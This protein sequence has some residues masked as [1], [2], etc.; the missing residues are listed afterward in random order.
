MKIMFYVIYATS[1][2][3][4][5]CSNADPMA[6]I[7]AIQSTQ[8]ENQNAKE[9]GHKLTDLAGKAA[10]PVNLEETKVSS[11]LNKNAVPYIGRYRVEINCSDPYIGCEQGT[12]NFILNLLADGTA[13]R[14]IV[15]MGKITFNSSHQY[16]QDHW[17]YDAINH[18]II[19]Q[20]ESGVKFYYWIQPDQNL[21]MDLNKI[22]HADPLNQ[23]FFEEG[24]PLPQQSYVLE[25][26][27]NLI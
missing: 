22:A 12:A 17:L 8:L 26:K 2:L 18:Q 9:S 21:K 6:E 27:T 13:H 7:D 1:P 5:A 23:A 25:K 11:V 4:V 20:R 19:V 14:S 24:N 3:L 16:Q 10:M 15:H